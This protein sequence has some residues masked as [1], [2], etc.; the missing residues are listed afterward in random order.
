MSE[1]GW[2]SALAV[3]YRGDMEQDGPQ[4]YTALTARDPRFDGVFFVGVT[5][6]GIYCR[7]ICPARTPK[8]SNCRSSTHRSW[9]NTPASGPASAAGPNWRPA[10][11]RW[12][13]RD[14]L[15]S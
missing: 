8:R 12:T 15:R 4:L 11:R 10:V 3:P 9:P 5:S 7:P 1:N 14:A 2:I 6:T 13:T